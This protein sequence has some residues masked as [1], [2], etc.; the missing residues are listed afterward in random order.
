M[1]VPTRRE[2]QIML[3]YLAKGVNN[4]LTVISF[5][6][7]FSRLMCLGEH[8]CFIVRRHLYVTG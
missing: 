7:A 4:H 1:N 3:D 8:G 5:A 2:G 6:G